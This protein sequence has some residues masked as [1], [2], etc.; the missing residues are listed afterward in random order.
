MKT[1]E[2]IQKTSMIGKILSKIVYI[3]CIVG[4]IGCVVGIIGIIVG[5]HALSFRGLTLHTL[6]VEEGGESI[7][8]VWAAIVS[9]IIICIGEFFVAKLSY[10]YFRNELEDGTPFTE[11]GSKE[12]LRLGIHIIW[13]PI[14]TSILTSIAKGIIEHIF[15]DV[16]PLE[17][18]VSSSVTLGIMFIIMS[19]I[20]RYGSEILNDKE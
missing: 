6:I 16:K 14:A 5:D 20:C 2:I 1:I 9:G 18:D 7:G 3:C 4:L 17:S 8:T 15:I 12:M 13:I 19:L 10:N 11:E